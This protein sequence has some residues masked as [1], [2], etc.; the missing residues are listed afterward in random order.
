MEFLKKNALKF[1]SEAKE[2]F[3]KKDY[4]LT[5]FFVEQFFQLALKYILYKKYGDFPKTHSLKMLFE[6]TKDENLIK[7][8]RENLDLFRDIELSY[9]AARYFDVEY[10]E[11]VA[12]KSL[13][14]AEDF[15]RWLK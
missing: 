7:Y 5:M 2:A 12:K 6:L 15:V 1:L 3:D 9:I 8:Y 10:S 4:N 13:K 11:N 14:L